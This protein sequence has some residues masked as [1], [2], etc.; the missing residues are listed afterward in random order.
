MDLNRLSISTT[1][2]T[3]YNDGTVRQGESKTGNAIPILSALSIGKNNGVLLF[4][5]PT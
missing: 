5:N 4:A 3:H 2:D 1:G